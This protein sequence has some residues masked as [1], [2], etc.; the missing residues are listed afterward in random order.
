MLRERERVKKDG[1]VAASFTA[2]Q[3]LASKIEKMPAW[4]KYLKQLGLS[5]EPIL[6]KADLKR[7]ADQAMKN[8]QRIIA[9]GREGKIV[10]R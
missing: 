7:E 9:K 2:Y 1:L 5:N 6:T 4:G 10:S 3:I 8:A